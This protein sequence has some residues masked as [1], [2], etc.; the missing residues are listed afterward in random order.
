MHRRLHRPLEFHYQGIKQMP[1]DYNEW[2]EL[3]K[4]TVQHAVTKYTLK[5]VQTWN[6][7]VWNEL[8]GMDNK[9]WATGDYMR[10]YNSSALAVKV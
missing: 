2:Y 9:D 8:W 1:A 7:E 4:A 3:V 5:E 10:L 6:F